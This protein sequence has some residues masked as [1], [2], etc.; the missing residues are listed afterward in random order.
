MIKIERWLI[1]HFLTWEILCEPFH[2]FSLTKSV[3]VVNIL[4]LF[5]DYRLMI[6]PHNWITPSSGTTKVATDILAI[7]SFVTAM[8]S[9]VFYI[10]LLHGCIKKWKGLTFDTSLCNQ[11]NYV[12]FDMACLASSNTSMASPMF[13]TSAL[14]IGFTGCHPP[15]CLIWRAVIWSSCTSTVS[16]LA[17]ECGLTDHAWNK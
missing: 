3:Y 4:D 16:E 11:L 1:T 5:V 10:P 13:T 17:S 15:L 2:T 7:F 14:G 6:G 9:V 8:C 12:H